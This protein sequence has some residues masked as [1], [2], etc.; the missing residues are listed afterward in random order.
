[1]RLPEGLSLLSETEQ[2]K[3]ALAG[4][5]ASQLHYCKTFSNKILLTHQDK[6]TTGHSLTCLAVAMTFESIL[7]Y[8]P[9]KTLAVV[10]VGSIGQSSLILLLEK[11]IKN[12]LPKIILC[13]LKSK[14]QKLKTFAKALRVKYQADISI[15]FYDDACDDASNNACND[16]SNDACND[17]SFEQIYTTDMFL[18]ASSAPHVLN[19]QKLSPGSILIDDSFPPVISV[20][21]SIQRMKS[22]EDILTLGGGKLVL[23]ATKF[24]SLSWKIPNLFL[25]GLLGQLGREGVPGCWLEALVFAHYNEEVTRGP[26]SPKKALSLMEV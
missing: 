21:E 16:T 18:G 3:I 20:K 15:V 17:T 14:E 22:T 25:S 8:T 7:K 13:D 4:Q 19:S 10:G 5:L 9:C 11:V 12:R 1:M 23:P 2:K 26:I 6:I 24:K